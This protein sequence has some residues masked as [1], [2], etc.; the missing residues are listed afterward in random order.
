LAHANVKTWNHANDILQLEIH[1]QNNKTNRSTGKI[2]AQVSADAVL[3]GNTSMRPCPPSPLLDFHLSLR[4]PQRINNDHTIDFE[5]HHFEISAT[6]RKSV[7]IVHHPNT[8][9]RVLDYPPKDAWPSVLGAF[10]L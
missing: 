2:P 5:G 1:R 6:K 7:S 4:T 8:K 10:S 3:T 9:F